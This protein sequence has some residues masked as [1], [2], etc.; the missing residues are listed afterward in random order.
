MVRSVDRLPD[1]DDGPDH[2]VIAAILE[3]VRERT[4]VDFSG[5]RPATVRRRLH[6]RMLGLSVSTVG[7]YL[8]VLRASS[9][10][11]ARLLERL[12]IKVSHFYRNPAAFDVLRRDVVPRLAAAAGPRPL[13]LWSAGCG[14]GE[15][16]Y[17][18]AMV[19]ED[20]GC[21]GDVLGTDVDE[22]ALELAASACYADEALRE[23]PDDWR[24]RYLAAAVPPLRR[25][26]RVADAVR[27]RVRFARHDLCSG[28]AEPAVF[29]LV[30]CR[31]VLIY[32]RRTAQDTVLATLSG[33]LAPGGVLM[34]GEAEW[35][36]GDWERQFDVVN[37]QWR[38]LRQRAG[39]APMGTA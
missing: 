8:H 37:R 18:L 30:C 3:T 16:A 39:T 12:T 27:R 20:A 4:G 6:N 15:E 11:A 7:D 33:A 36:P 29:D 10:E 26:C 31:N 5:Y 1:P 28:S 24:P 19:L 22:S 35:P 25:P 14:R 21:D 23:L 38:I 9:D 17:T 32:L 13:R 2:A 34:L